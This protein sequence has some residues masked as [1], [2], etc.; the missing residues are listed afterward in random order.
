MGWK[1]A[2][3]A[4]VWPRNAPRRGQAVFGRRSVVDLVVAVASVVEKRGTIAWSVSLVW[5]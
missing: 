3:K 2:A 1:E 5:K 4:T